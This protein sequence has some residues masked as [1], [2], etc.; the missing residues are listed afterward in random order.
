MAKTVDQFSTIENFR[1]KYN[2]LAVDV[3]DS[4]GLRTSDSS[5]IVDAVNSIEDK[6]FFFQEY[7]YIAAAAQN[8]FSGND[9]FGHSLKFRANRIQVFKNSVHLNET[10]DYSISG[11]VDA[12]HTVISLTSA[13]SAGDKIT[14]YSFTGSY[15]GTA[16]NSD[17]PV[18]QFA[19]TAVNTIYNTNTNGVILN[20]D[21]TPYQTSVL[22][23]GYNIQ[24][25]GK[26]F[27][28]DDILLTTG[29]TL[30]APRIT[31]GTALITNAIGT[32]FTSFTSTEFYGNLTGTTADLTGTV[33]ANNFTIGGASI[34]ETDLEKI[35]DLTN[36]TVIHSKAVAVDTNKDITGFRNVTLTGEL[37]AGSLDVSGNSDIAGNSEVHGTTGSD[38]DF[39]VGDSGGDKFNV[40]AITGNTQIDGTLEVD[41]TTGL[42]GDLRVGDN[43]FNVTALTGNTQIDGQLEVDGT[44]G[45]DG[46]FRVGSAGASNFNITAASGNTQIDGTLNVDSHTDLNSSVTVDGVSEFN[47]TVGVDGNFRVGSAGASKFDVAAASGNTQIDGTLNVDGTTNLDVVDIDGAVDMATTLQVDGVATFTG[48]DVHSG[49]ITIANAGQIGSVGD[50]DAIA[51]ASDGV[52]TLTQKLV[53]TEL[54]ISGNI[55]VDGTTNLDIVDIDGAVH[56]QTNLTVVGGIDAGSVETDLLSLNSVTVTST[57]AELNYNDGITLGTALASKVLSSDANL[58]TT[59]IRNL[60]TSGDVTVGGNLTV[61]GTTTTLNSTTVEIADD[62][63]RVNSAGGNN[64]AG[65][66]AYVNS[67]AKQ[68]IYD[69]SES[70]WTFGSENV[71]ATSFEGALTGNVTGNVTGN[72]DTATTLATART[73]AGQSFNGSANISIGAS[74][75]SDINYTTTPAAGQ[76]LIWDAGNG[77]WEPTNLADDTDSYAEGTNNKYFTDDRVNDTIVAGTGISKSY[78]DGAGVTDGRTTLNIGEGAG[79]DVTA[80]AVALDYELVSVA[81]TVVGGTSTGHLWFVI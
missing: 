48:R 56:M 31:D 46:N 25:A 81:P 21:G 78:V 30:T 38:G 47:S 67:V 20:G 77:Y 69:A 33:T 9:S 18:G 68:I 64:D 71:K 13:A 2:E 41:G 55:D 72:A 45:V 61:S 29:K 24:L 36:G 73:I 22:E 75:L 54:D 32:A 53:G 44:A 16:A 79:I 17:Q 51:I 50:T 10:Y 60:T 15:L 14:I 62:I 3:G 23:T 19:E 43:K 5:T 76:A 11:P 70:E 80:D 35:D 7:V 27:A 49:G 52:V 8:A 4:A 63:F 59:G 66:E 65:F 58:D 12:E 26:T 40:A 74:S 34:D 42:D 57:A 37:D 39:R 6:S 28:E 1:T